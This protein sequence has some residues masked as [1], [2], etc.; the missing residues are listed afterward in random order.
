MVGAVGR[1]T[2]VAEAVDGSA[3]EIRSKTETLNAAIEGFLDDV[4][5]A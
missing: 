4:A 2:Q 1:T 5:A 3:R